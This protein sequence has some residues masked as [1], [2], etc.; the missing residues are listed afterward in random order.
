MKTE[1]KEELDRYLNYGIK[2]GGFLIAVLEN[3]LLEA[4]CRADAANKLDLH[5]IV[6]YV[7]AYFPVAC[8]QSPER[9]KLWIA[10]GG[11]PGFEAGLLAQA[12]GR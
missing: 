7:Y 1:I 11:L 5:E 8:W 2:P 12:K 4:V 3:N 9:V 6:D 10:V